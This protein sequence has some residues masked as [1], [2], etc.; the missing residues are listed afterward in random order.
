MKG[1]KSLVKAGL[2]SICYAPMKYF[3]GGGGLGA[4]GVIVFPWGGATAGIQSI[5]LFMTSGP[6]SSVIE[7]KDLGIG[8]PN[9]SLPS[10]I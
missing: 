7:I 5:Y 2:Q 6:L 8:Q 10:R 3:L 9:L 1:P 4:R